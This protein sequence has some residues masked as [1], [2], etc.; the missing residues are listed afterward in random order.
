MHIIKTDLCNKM[1]DDWLNNLLLCYIEKGIFR[2][3]DIDKV[4]KRFQAIKDRR[5]NLPK[6]PTQSGV[7]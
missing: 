5:V 6:G 3:L 2:G 7:S 1:C 4:K